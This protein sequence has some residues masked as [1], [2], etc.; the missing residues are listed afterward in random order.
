MDSLWSRKICEVCVSINFEGAP[1]ILIKHWI[2]FGLV[3]NGH[4][5]PF[6]N[7]VKFVCMMKIFFY[8]N[9]LF[10]LIINKYINT[11]SVSS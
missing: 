5:I 4:P 11:D 3:P 1:T 6:V 9:S 10:L 2:E 7:H 8:I